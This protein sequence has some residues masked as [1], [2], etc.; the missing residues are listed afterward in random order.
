MKTNI[1]YKS[2]FGSTK[3]Y[4]YW[5]HNEL[6]SNIFKFNEATGDNLAEAEKIIVLSGTYAGQMPLVKFLIEHWDKIQTKKVIVVAVGAGAAD[7]EGSETSHNLIPLNIQ[8]KISY[9]KLPGQM[10]NPEK[11]A[12]KSENLKPVLELIN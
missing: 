2:T 5:L 1:Y 10:L 7:S 11:N 9:I 3:K 8:K 12:V 6:D 4:A